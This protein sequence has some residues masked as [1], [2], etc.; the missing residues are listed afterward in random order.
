M[1]DA[2]QPGTTRFI[3]LKD[4]T[5]HPLA[6]RRFDEARAKQIADEF[7]PALLGEITVAET[8]RG[9]SWV[10][11]G[12]TRRAACLL[13]LEADGTQ[14]VL[15]RV[16]PVDNDAEAARL[17]LGLNNH[18]AVRVFDKFVVRAVAKDPVVLGIIAI[19]DK[20]G[21]AVERYL[22]EGKIRAVDALES[23]FSRDGGG[24]LLDRVI[25]IL[26]RTWGRDP[27]AYHGSIIRG[28]ALLLSRYDKLIDNDELVR[29]MAKHSGPLGLIGR[30]RDLK[31]AIGGSA[32]QAIAE[33]IRR[34]YNKGRRNDRLSDDKAA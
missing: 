28:L 34:E 31:A 17:F 10:V 6:Q 14:Q 20:H 18:K 30:A 21:L 19:L 9:K 7:D 23:V 27:D 13:F 29:K 16:I 11:D 3:A 33:H 1:K 12:Q 8:K 4:L 22:V 2:F 24:K 25:G 26:H 15:C 5:P 32:A